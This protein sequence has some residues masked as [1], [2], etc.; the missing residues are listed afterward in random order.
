MNTLV[1]ETRNILFGKK[2]VGLRFPAFLGVCI[3]YFADILSLL[4]SKKLPISSIRVK[5]FLSNS[6]F[7]TSA[8]R[9]GFNPAKSLKKGLSQTLNYEFIEDNSDK[10]TFETE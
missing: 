10:Q 2:N 4:T 8:F 3:G 7:D 5:K 1:S 6:Q 9:T